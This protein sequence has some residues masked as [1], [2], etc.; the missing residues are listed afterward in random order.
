MSAGSTSGQILEE[1]ADFSIFWHNEADALSPLESNLRFIAD[2]SPPALNLGLSYRSCNVILITIDTLR[3]D[4]LSCYNP[5]ASPTPNI[6]QLAR[7]GVLFRNAFS[8]VPITLPSH[9]AILSSHPPEELNLFNNGDTY[10]DKWPLLPDILSE[11]RYH[12]AGFISLVVLRGEFGLGHHFDRYED[13]FDTYHRYYKVAS[14]M[15]ALALP[16]IKK[17]RAHRFFAWIHYSD[18]HEPYVTVN[19]PPDT[20]IV[21]NGVD[22][23]EYCFR[24]R[25][26]LNLSFVARTGE[27]TVE[28]RALTL[29]GSTRRFLEKRTTI[30]PADGMELQYGSEWNDFVLPAGLPARSFTKSGI[31]KI[32][33]KNSAPVKTVLQVFGGVHGQ[34]I[35]EIRRNYTAEL[36]YTDRYIG[37]VRQT[38]KDFNLQNKTI[39]VLTADHGE[40][41][42]THEFVSHVNCLY[43]ETIHVPLII[44]DPVLG[45]RHRE[46]NEKVSHL[47]IV[48]TILDLLHIDAANLRGNSLQAFITFSPIDRIFSRKPQLLRVFSSTYAPQAEHDSFSIIDGNY[49]LI[50]FPDRKTHRYQAYDLSR[51]PDERHDLAELAPAQGNT[52]ELRT[53][54]S[55]LDGYR[56]HVATI[57]KRNHTALD[58]EQ[59]NA[60]EALGYTHR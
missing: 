31:L 44:Y 51:D 40:G 38:L 47:D 39:I 14:E 17:E 27:N 34:S 16:W 4:Y 23:G 30:M 5:K 46:V 15:N 13:R 11:H 59:K 3:A 1:R 19:A 58:E 57:H 35:E 9:T 12:T 26:T 20:R 52:P 10:Y 37:Q 42:K 41:L 21:I 18:P 2:C 24:K 45:Y 56:N 60:L 32:V 43:N 33:N 8:M 36:Q 53:A 25:E 28:F 6:D 48:P 55:L 50:D 22:G 49:K 7:D 54:L 29:P